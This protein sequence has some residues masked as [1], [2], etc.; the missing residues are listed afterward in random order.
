MKTDNTYKHHLNSGE[1]VVFKLTVGNFVYPPYAFST[2]D[3][4][5]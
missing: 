3:P 5:R 1:L 2:L 4:T